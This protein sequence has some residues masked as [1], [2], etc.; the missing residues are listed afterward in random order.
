MFIKLMKICLK[1]W[2]KTCFHSHF[3]ANFHGSVTLLFLFGFSWN[4]QQ[5]VELRNWEWYTPFWEVFAHFLIGKELIFGCKSG[6]GK[7]LLKH[8]AWQCEQQGLHRLEKYLNIQSFLKKSPWKLN[9]PWKVLENHFV[10]NYKSNFSTFNS[11]RIK[12][13]K[14]LGKSN[15][16]HTRLG[17]PLFLPMWDISISH[18]PP[19]QP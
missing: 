10:V 15:F 13:A 7:S 5:N 6:L 1:M 16:T 9:L 11:A 14:I 17:F 8:L 2:I 4:F 3:Y 18:I 12:F 19:Y